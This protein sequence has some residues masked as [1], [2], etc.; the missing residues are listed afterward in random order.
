MIVAGLL[1]ACAGPNSII[2]QISTE[3]VRLESENQLIYQLGN[4]L[5]DLKRVNRVAYRILTAN[6]RFCQSYKGLVFGF[7]VWN[8]HTVEPKIRSAARARWGL[9]DHLGV[10]AVAPRS[11]AALA[12]IAAPSRLSAMAAS[13]SFSAAS[14][15]V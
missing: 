13:G 3:A 2:P 10:L 1:S 11:A 14:T 8:S 15:A 9:S 4:R 5:A 7:L 12:S 6:T